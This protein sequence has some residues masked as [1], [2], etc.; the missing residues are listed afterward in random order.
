MAA[1]NTCYNL[2]NTCYKQA[3]ALVDHGHIT[4]AR[5][6]AARHMVG[7][8][9]VWVVTIANYVLGWPWG[10]TNE[11]VVIIKGALLFSAYGIML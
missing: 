11:W 10:V 1:F 7:V 6:G 4:C 3:S 9:F 8:T 2:A 5:A